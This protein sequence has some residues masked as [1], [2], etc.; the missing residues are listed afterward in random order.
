MF[1]VGEMDSGRPHCNGEPNAFASSTRTTETID[2]R[3]T[4][5]EV[6]CTQRLCASTGDLS[7]GANSARKSRPEPSGSS[8]ES[9]EYTTT[10]QQQEERNSSGV[11]IGSS[12]RSRITGEL[13]TA[14]NNSKS[15]E[16]SLNSY[17]SDSCSESKL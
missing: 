12:S 16:V 3:N 13:E 4:G 8:S 6:E 15:T 2:Y 1:A 9:L 11:S 7:A 14:R 10:G 5:L 17:C